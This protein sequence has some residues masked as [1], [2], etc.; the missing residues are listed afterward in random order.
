M[1]H[2]SAKLSENFHNFGLSMRKYSSLKFQLPFSEVNYSPDAIAILT[3]FVSADINNIKH[4][5]LL[6]N[7][8]SC[9]A[10]I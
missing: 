7:F 8:Q 5:M 3:I 6:R 2:F 10:H 1:Q 9:S 4:L